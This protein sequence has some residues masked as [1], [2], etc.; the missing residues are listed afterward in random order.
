MP[1][2]KDHPPEE[3]ILE[4]RAKQVTGKVKEEAGKLVGDRSTEWSGKAEQVHGKVLEGLGRATDRPDPDE[5]V[6]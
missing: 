2:T 5:P 4:G 1:H 6:R 3:E